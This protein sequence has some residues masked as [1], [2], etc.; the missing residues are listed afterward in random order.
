MSREK[1]KNIDLFDDL[2]MNPL[3]ELLE[4]TRGITQKVE[5]HPEGD[6]LTHSLQTLS[7][8]FR[9]SKD[10]DLILAS[11]LHDVGKKENI[12][13]HA[14]IGAK[15][16]EGI[17]G[18][19][20]VW[21]VRNHLR[22]VNYLDGSMNKLSKCLTLANHPWLPELIQLRRWDNKG[23]NPDIPVFYSREKITRQLNILVNQKYG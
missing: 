21:L 2:I 15:W 18:P 3:F 7:H 20:T 8:A 22:I 5:N 1:C 17:V 11:M 14:K 19:K 16:L 4:N 9:E 6:V 13:M 12:L 23:R 10:T